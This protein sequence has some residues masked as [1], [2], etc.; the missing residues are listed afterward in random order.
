MGKVMICMERAFAQSILADAEDVKVIILNE[1]IDGIED[2]NP[3]LLSVIIA[4]Y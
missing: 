3:C 2:D 4:S 1:V